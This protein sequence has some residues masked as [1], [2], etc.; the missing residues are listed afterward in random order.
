[1]GQFAAQRRSESSLGHV[2]SWVSTGSSVEHS[3]GMFGLAC[4]ASS[5]SAG[6]CPC[7]V[8]SGLALRFGREQPE[9]QRV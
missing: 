5:V 4:A 9:V 2:A 3:A 1:V 8:L 7:K 6:C